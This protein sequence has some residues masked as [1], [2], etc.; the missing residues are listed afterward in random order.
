MAAILPTISSNQFSCI[1]IGLSIFEFKN[2]LRQGQ[3]NVDTAFGSDNGLMPYR[4]Q[5]IIRSSVGLAYGWIYASFGIDELKYRVISKGEFM[6]LFSKLYGCCWWNCVGQWY[7][8]RFPSHRAIHWLLDSHHKRP[9]MR[10]TAPSHG[11]IMSQKYI[12]CK[13]GTWGQ[14]GAHLAP[15]GPRWAPCWS[16][17]LCYLGIHCSCDGQGVPNLK[18]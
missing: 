2:K 12:P 16:H 7:I 15:V 9:I 10:Q 14:H 5:A 18:K 1:K 13:Q 17:E 6:Q 4:R 8:P 3:I 11:A